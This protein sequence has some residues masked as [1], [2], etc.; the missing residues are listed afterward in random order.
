MKKKYQQPR[1]EIAEFLFSE[2]IACAS[3]SECNEE[4]VFNND[5]PP[6]NKSNCAS[7]Y[8]NATKFTK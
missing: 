1:L 3:G 2:H 8:P 7:P 6:S 5:R 4:P